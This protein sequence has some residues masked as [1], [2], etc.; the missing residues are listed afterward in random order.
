MFAR[1]AAP[2][3]ATVW[4][5]AVCMGAVSL[6]LW[7][8]PARFTGSGIVLLALVIAFIVTWFFR[9]P[10]RFPRG[11]G[12]VSPADGTVKRVL[13][14]GERQG[15]SIFMNVYDVHVN[16]VPLA[17]TLA[18]KEYRAGAHIPAF[19]KD[20]DRNERLRTFWRTRDGTMQMDQ[21]AGTVARRTVA[22]TEPGERKERG[23][24]FGMILFSSRVDLLLPP[25]Y[26]V[27]VRV[28][29][30]VKAGETVIARKV[31]EFPAT[32]PPEIAS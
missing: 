13:R 30:H 4:V 21:I 5:I 25:G 7:P 8:T 26:E 23:E 15:I 14:E 18:R 29:Q 32:L 2:F 6:L 10:E 27:C 31:M 19:H 24:R 20:S 1:G 16:R 17:G 11:P 28:G 9:D 12:A 3:L 22:W